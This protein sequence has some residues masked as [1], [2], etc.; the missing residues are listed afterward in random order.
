MLVQLNVKCAAFFFFVFFFFVVVFFFF[1]CLFFFCFFC[2]LY[3]FKEMTSTTF[4]IN[5]KSAYTSTNKNM[6][7]GVTSTAPLLDLMM[8]C[9][10]KTQLLNKDKMSQN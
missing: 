4:L 1:F 5:H 10:E 6:N 2:F 7:I 3:F 9:T 8:V